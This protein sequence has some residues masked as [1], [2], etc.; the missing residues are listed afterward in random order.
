MAL[1]LVTTTVKVKV[2]PGAGRVRG[3]AVLSTAM[4]GTTLVRRT[5]ASSVAVTIGA[6]RAPADDGDDVGLGGAGRRR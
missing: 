2:P 3:L 5:V 1:V 4:T 6:R